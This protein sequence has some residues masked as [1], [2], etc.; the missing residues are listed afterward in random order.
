MRLLIGGAG[1]HGR[2]LADAA[3]SSG[4]F[5][6]VAFLDD[7]FPGLV[8]PEGWPV[9][10]KLA[11]LKLLRAQFDHYAA[12]FG[13]SNLRLSTLRSARDLGY[14][15]PS[16]RHESSHV[17]RYATVDAG[18][19]LLAGSIINIGARVGV[20][21]IINVGASVDHDCVLD[22]GVHICPGAHLGGDTA[23]GFCSWF[24]IGAVTRQGVKI[25]REVTVG[26]GAVVVADVADGTTVI[27]N[28]AK[29]WKK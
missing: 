8:I 29:P 4:A 6:D 26:A 21:C 27:G 3:L 19:V 20:G 24:G 17:S 5:A 7:R 12:G 13:N 1:G 11:D 9:I 23:I 18:C 14:S 16:I 25:G 28:P 10:G 2:V 22:D 15:L